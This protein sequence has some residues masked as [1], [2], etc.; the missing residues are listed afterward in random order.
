MNEIPIIP[1]E[2][3]KVMF[4]WKM[5]QFKIKGSLQFGLK[6]H[7]GADPLVNI[8]LIPKDMQLFSCSF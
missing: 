6:S 5:K 2:Y 7:R 1:R 4:R 3:I 8:F